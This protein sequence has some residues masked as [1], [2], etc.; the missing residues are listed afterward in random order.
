MPLIKEAHMRL[1]L[2]AIAALWAM[3]AMGCDMAKD[4]ATT[5]EEGGAGATG[6]AEKMSQGTV[7]DANE[8]SGES[9]TA[10]E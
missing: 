9:E 5:T 2:I 4:T 7:G 8:D 1:L 10:G 3:L 6:I